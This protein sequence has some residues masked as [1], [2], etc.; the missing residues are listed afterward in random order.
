MRTPRSPFPQILILGVSAIVVASTIARAQG[1]VFTHD[2]SFSY[3]YHVGASVQ[4]IV[5]YNIGV[6][7]SNNHLLNTLLMKLAAAVF[8]V[9]ELALR[10]PNLLAQWMYLLASFLILRRLSHPIVMLAGFIILNT[11]PLALDYFALARGYGLSLGF[12]LLSLYF[13]TRHQASRSAADLFFA[14]FFGM[15]A[16][17]S[18]MPALPPS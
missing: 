15:L 1:M 9:S 16:V 8:G 7:P 2:E 11:N 12:I 4:A 3:V 5:Q 6:A 10:S 18:S 14:S 13:C 17:L